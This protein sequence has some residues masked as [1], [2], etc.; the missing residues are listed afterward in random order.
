[1]FVPRE[2]VQQP[3]MSGD[4]SFSAG[5]KCVEVEAE[6][7]HASGEVTPETREPLVEESMD[8]F[9]GFD[10]DTPTVVRYGQPLRA[11]FAT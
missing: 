3:H 9:D 10:G 5:W 4:V 2:D 8:M 11:A 7:E 6:C 1:M